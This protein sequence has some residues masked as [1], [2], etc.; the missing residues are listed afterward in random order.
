M[1]VISSKTGN[2]M[3]VNDI[4]ARGLRR[5]L[6]VFLLF[7]LF[8]CDQIPSP[9]DARRTAPVSQS[10]EAFARH[11]LQELAAGHIEQV[12][13]HV[14]P[15]QGLRLAPYAALQDDDVI[16]KPA[17]LIEAWH[18]PRQIQWGYYDGSGEPIVFDLPTYVASFVTERNYA[19]APQVAVN[20]VLGRGNSPFN[21]AD[22]YPDS[23]FVEF[24]YPGADPAYEGMDWYSLRLVL[25]QRAAG[26]WWLLA[27]V[28]DQWTI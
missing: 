17:A 10:P 5:A 23:I 8:S 3:S 20:R 13:G 4:A 26:G 9:E 25:Q 19:A 15:Q 6:G 21:V 12:A 16:L 11:L 27:L 2:A 18:Q 14:S 28:H 1:D 22:Y 7:V 24:H